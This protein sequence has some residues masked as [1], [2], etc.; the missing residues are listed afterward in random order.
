MLHV[1]DGGREGEE[2]RML[3]FGMLTTYVLLASLINLDGPRRD[4][5]HPHLMG[6]N[7]RID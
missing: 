2:Q 1:E 6:W 5:M 4:V 7:H 3:A